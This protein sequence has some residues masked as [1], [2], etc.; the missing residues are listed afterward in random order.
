MF[1]ALAHHLRHALTSGRHV[2]L[3]VEWA[4]FDWSQL[5]V[6]TGSRLAEYGQS[7]PRKGE[8]FA[9]VPSTVHAG[10]WADKPIAFVRADFTFYDGSQL[11]RPVCAYLFQVRQGSD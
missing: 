1:V 8:Q 6:F 2:I 4:I 9:V 10:N 3:Q 7:K 11:Q 5:G